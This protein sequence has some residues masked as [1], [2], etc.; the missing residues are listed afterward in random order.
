MNLPVLAYRSPALCSFFVSFLYQN[1]LAA[2]AGWQSSVWL[3]LYN[4]LNSD[5][6]FLHEGDALFPVLCQLSLILWTVFQYLIYC[7][8]RTVPAYP[9]S[10]G[11]REC[12][13]E[14]E[15][16]LWHYLE[17]LCTDLFMKNWR[18]LAKI[19]SFCHFFGC[20]TKPCYVHFCPCSNSRSCLEIL[21]LKS[22]FFSGK[23][24]LSSV[25]YRDGNKEITFVRMAEQ[26]N[27]LQKHFVTLSSQEENLLRQFFG[28]Q[29]LLEVQ[30]GGKVGSDVC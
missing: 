9:S 24:K 5:L 29:N 3:F 15:L 18:E 8:V 19:E 2:L 16:C 25:A 13:C 1:F 27:P 21:N 30:S 20:T 14:L 12:L 17:Y 28:S 26:K 10:D 23:S 11:S 6:F 22:I 7:R 4:F